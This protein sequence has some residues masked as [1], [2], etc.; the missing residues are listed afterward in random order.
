VRWQI[1]AAAGLFAAAAAWVVAAGRLLEAGA[2]PNRADAVVVLSGDRQG[3]RLAK[4]VAVLKETGSGLLVVSVPGPH[5]LPPPRVKSFL[6]E[7]GV[8]PGRVRYVAPMG[9]TSEEARV[10]AGLMR[11][12]GWRSVVVVT[13]PYHTRRAGWLFRRAVD[14]AASVTTVD[15]DEPFRAGAWWTSSRGAKAVFQE[16]AKGAYALRYLLRPLRPRD[17]GVGC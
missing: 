11:R 2:P 1:A 14:R 4:A 13:S 16:W 12:C 3:S 17:P 8:A 9:G 6:A 10:T 7:Q 5:A 15:D